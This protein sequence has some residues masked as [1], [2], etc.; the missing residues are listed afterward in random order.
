MKLFVDTA[1]IDEIEQAN[2]WGIL[3]GVT[4]NPSLLKHAV[5]ARRGAPGA[6]GATSESRTGETLNIE[7][8]LERIL[9]TVGPGKPVSLEVISTTYEAMRTEALQL[10]E[11]FNRV[12]GNVVI[13]VPVNPT[14]EPD[15]GD[16]ADGLRTIAELTAQGMPVNVTLVM[17]PTQALLAAKAG[18]AYVSP[19]AG[20][21]DD[22][23]RTRAGVGFDKSDYYP[24]GGMPRLDKEGVLEYEGIVSGVDL[25]SKIVAIFDRFAI[26]TE[27]LAASLRNPQQVAEVAVAGADVATVPFAVL[28]SLLRHPKTFEGMQ[29]FVADVVD[30]YRAFFTQTDTPAPTP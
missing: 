22:Y 9:T 6:S 10:Y 15:K 11:R 5:E 24:A 13:K 19:F 21:I 23:L 2:S 29:K 17:N 12:A 4:T 8:Y 26:E 1:E 30:E 14:L 18:A 25:V 27:V 7:S 20:R 3:D 16:D 28:R